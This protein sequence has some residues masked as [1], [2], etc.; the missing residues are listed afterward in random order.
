[1]R[2]LLLCTLFLYHSCGNSSSGGSSSPTINP[3]PTP[4]KLDLNTL[5]LGIK[6]ND[7]KRETLADMLKGRKVV[8]M[9]FSGVF[10][11][12]CQTQAQDFTRKLPESIPHSV[13]FLD[14]ESSDNVQADFDDFMKIYAPKSL[15][16]FDPSRKL[17]RT[18]HKD[19]DIKFGSALAVSANGGTYFQE[20]A[21]G[22]AIDQF[23]HEIVSL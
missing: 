22:N 16:R 14:A 9:Q 5:T 21:E 7:P 19:P 23:M 3:S 12:S 8:V 2:L 1:M 17:Y 15:A 20:A 11:I 10:C 6:Y 13:V 4:S 18:F